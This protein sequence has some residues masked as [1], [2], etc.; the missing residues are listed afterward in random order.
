MPANLR[1]LAATAI[2]CAGLVALPAAAALYKWTDANGRVV[3]SD[4]P[5]SAAATKTETLASPPPAANPNAAKEMAQ[6]EADLRKRATERADAST[7]ADKE[8][9]AKE[10]RAEECT[11][12]AS[13]LKQLAWSQVVIYRANE[14]GEQVA[15]DDAAKARE[16]A[17]LEGLQKEHC[18]S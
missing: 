7:K 13:T 16:R 5:P 3:Y 15:M 11:R 10:Q 8:R 14:K 1:V 6:K 12:I 9:S 18:A 4:Q 17:R 2:A